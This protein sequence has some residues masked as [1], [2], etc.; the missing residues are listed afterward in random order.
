MSSPNASTATSG[1]RQVMWFATIAIVGISYFIM[2]VATL[3]FLRTDYNPLKEHISAYAVGRYGVL[4]TSAFF[5][6]ALGAL[7]LTIGLWRGV[8]AASS[9]RFGLTL[10]VVFA[11][12][13]A[14]A[15][16]FPTDLEGAPPTTSGN[17]HELAFLLA[18]VSVLAA[19][20]LW[21][22]KFQRDDTWQAANRAALTLA[23]LALLAFIS[24]FAT[25]GTEFLGLSQRIFVGLFLAWM[26]LTSFRL[27]S[28]NTRTPS[29]Q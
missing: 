28:G 5:A 27:R 17:I 16:I 10:L 7:F 22:R 21:S 25:E 4:M 18:S 26:L 19:M 29:I 2:A 12:C 9:S 3:H 1:T 8:S 11:L 15:G 24:L 20:F 6:L 14:T 13:V 23:V